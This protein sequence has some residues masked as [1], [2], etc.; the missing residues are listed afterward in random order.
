MTGPRP[1]ESSRA[2]TEASRPGSREL[3]LL[4]DPSWCAAV[5]VEAR[6]R[7]PPIPGDAPGELKPGPPD[8]GLASAGLPVLRVATED[9]VQRG[10]L[11]DPWASI[12]EMAADGQSA[13]LR[14]DPLGL[15]GAFVR[16][17]E[18]GWAVS[19]DLAT[20]LRLPPSP[21]PRP[22]A[23]REYLFYDGWIGSELPFEDVFQ[24]PSG[25]EWSLD[26]GRPRPE[27][28]CSPEM[29]P[30]H[31]A[32]R[33]TQDRPAQE[34]ARSVEQALGR[35]IETLASLGVPVGCFLSGGLDSGLIAAIAARRGVD[36]TLL[37]CGLDGTTMDE[38]GTACA[39]ARHLRMPHEVL[40]LARQE[41][42]AGLVDAVHNSGLPLSIP[43]QV[44]LALLSRRAEERGLGMV[45]CG[46]GG[47]EL[48]CGYPRLLALRDTLV[49]VRVGRGFDYRRCL[50]DSDLTREL[51]LI[52][53]P[54]DLCALGLG[55]PARLEVA[56]RVRDLMSTLDDPL[57][58]E[59]RIAWLHELL[60]TLPCNLLR[61]HNAARES[62][63]RIGLPFLSKEVVELAV[64]R[65]PT[66]SSLSRT[67]PLLREL[68]GSF[69]P[70]QLL[71]LPKCG[72]EIPLEAWLP[73]LTRIADAGFATAL[74]LP[75]A[76]VATWRR[77]RPA[78]ADLRWAVLNIEIWA[79][80]FCLGHSPAEV[81]RWLFE[82]G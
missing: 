38:T 48:F 68:A 69:L 45:L 35:S 77:Q 29:A 9:R 6:K 4:G 18:E 56:T 70:A 67:K 16:R 15:S 80:L 66:L 42:L 62:G 14:R 19:S 33:G 39:V 60:Q 17:F 75:E 1:A 10:M 72:F 63:L 82:V 12:I 73:P 24:T 53:S 32:A 11:P 22:A 46:E 13:C 71:S 54:F 30:F 20:L 2:A 34:S 5:A 40:N 37:T 58:R 79:R 64:G 51:H 78:S 61:L 23:L 41:F 36:L 27:L 44:G 26:L 47:D 7:G 59:L 81:Q 55:F 21:R 28:V 76:S 74:E 49:S 3:A 25:A 57:E 31:A 8:A 50:P 43:N 52:R 65:L